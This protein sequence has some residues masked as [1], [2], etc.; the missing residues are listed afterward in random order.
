MADIRNLYIEVLKDYDPYGYFE[1]QEYIE[2]N[3]TLNTMLYNLICITQLNFEDCTKEELKHD[4]IYNRMMTL[5]DLLT[6]LGGSPTI[7]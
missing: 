1:D 4:D 2:S 3:L 7:G 6:I 5:V